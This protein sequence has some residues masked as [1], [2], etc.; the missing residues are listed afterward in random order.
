MLD[1][2]GFAVAADNSHDEVKKHADMIA[3]SNN[4]GIIAYIVENLIKK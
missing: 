2:A 4:E 3:C 1:Y